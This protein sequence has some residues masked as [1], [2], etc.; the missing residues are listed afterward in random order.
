ML[1][2][3]IP[4]DLSGRTA[5][6]TGA[7]QGLGAAIATR[8]H[9]AGCAVAVTWWP[10]PPGVNRARAEAFVT[11]LGEGAIA[12]PADVRSPADLDAAVAATHARFGALDILVNNAG[13]VRDRTLRRMS[14]QE[15]SDV[16]DTNLTGVFNACKAVEPHLADG[17]RIVSISSISAALGFFGQANYAAAKAGV[18]GL[19]RVLA[20]ELARRAITVNAIAPVVALPE[21]GQT[22]P[23]AARARMLAEVPLGRFAEP[24]DIADAAL[25]LC[26]GLAAY[27]TGQTLHV[28][29]G[30]H[31]A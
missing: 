7:S 6:I 2:A 9:Q 27:V 24:G 3:M 19:T 29:G 26:S 20:R 11:G 8:L 13:I 4:I 1:I 30:W 17:G 21:M 12:I 5:L 10:D 23:E 15:W 22:I 16:V 25:F 14:A 28:N 31:P 18:I